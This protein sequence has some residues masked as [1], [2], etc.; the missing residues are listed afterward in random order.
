MCL[1][2][3]NAR[4]RD[5]SRQRT[6]LEF[7]LIN[8]IWTNR[9]GRRKHASG[10]GI[11]LAIRFLGLPARSPRVELPRDVPPPGSFPRRAARSPSS[12]GPRGEIPL[13]TY[14]PAE[15]K[16]GG[17]NLKTRRIIFSLSGRDSI[18]ACR[19]WTSLRP[20]QQSSD[21]RID[22]ISES[23]DKEKLQLTI[24]ATQLCDARI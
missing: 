9:Y 16:R 1:R 20:H 24:A 3:Q 21:S 2:A 10:T 19:R 17:Q 5:R 4:S 12:A 7:Q 6:D 23:L 13:C 22:I 11:P 18:S 14:Q 15:A 8:A